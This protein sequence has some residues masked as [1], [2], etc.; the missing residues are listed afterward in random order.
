MMHDLDLDISWVQEQERIH[1][2][3]QN[4]FREPLPYIH[5]VFLYINE[6]NVLE[7]ALKEKVESVTFASSSKLTKEQLTKL[8]RSKEKSTPTTKYIF[9]EIGLFQISLEPEMI[10]AFSKCST[11]TDYSFF[12]ILP[13]IEDI[14]I[15][16][17]IFIFHPFQTI[18]FIYNEIKLEEKKEIKSIIATQKR[19]TKRRV[20]MQIPRKTR[21]QN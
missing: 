16:P 6:N 18:Y 7:S 10:P 15:Q 1:Q 3:S 20:K 9:K 11:P 5:T 2:L 8:I 14:E 12:R 13:G 21:H 17:S 19:L 4:C